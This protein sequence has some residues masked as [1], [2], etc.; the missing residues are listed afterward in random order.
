MSFEKSYSKKERTKEIK[1]PLL[2]QQSLN[3]DHADSWSALD[4][5]AFAANLRTKYQATRSKMKE[6]RVTVS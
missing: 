1:E 2:P 5:V 6:Y 4:Y 3:L